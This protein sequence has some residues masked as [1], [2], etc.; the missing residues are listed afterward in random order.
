MAQTSTFID[1]I[2]KYKIN[3][4]RIQ[5]D[6]AQGRLSDKATVIRKSLVDTIVAV[7]DQEDK[8]KNL[9]FIYGSTNHCNFIPLDGQQRLTTLF[10]FH[11]Y[12]DWVADREAL[13]ENIDYQF[14]YATRDSST[15]FCEDFVKNKDVLAVEIKEPYTNY[16][17]R[18]EAEKEKN[19][20]EREK[21]LKSIPYPKNPSDIIRN[22]PWFFS[23]WDADPTVAGMLVMLDEIHSRYI[24]DFSGDFKRINHARKR[25][26]DGAVQFQFQ[27]LDNFTR[28]DDLFIK[29]NSRG[30]GLTDFEIFKSKIVEDF[31]NSCPDK[32]SD[33]KNKIDGEWC[34]FL[35]TL[36]SKV[37]KDL[38]KHNVDI[39]YQRLLKFLIASEA[40]ALGQKIA[41][42]ADELFERNNKTM[43]FAHNAY[44]GCDV[45]F[46]P[47][48]LTRV[49]EDVDF[50][51]NKKTS[52]LSTEGLMSKELSDLLLAG[53]QLSYDEFI[54]AYAWLRFSLLEKDD[55][56]LKDWMRTIRHLLDD[57]NVDSSTGLINAL[58]GVNTLLELYTQSRRNIY[59]W[60]ANTKVTKIEGLSNYQLQEEVV[61]AQLRVRPFGLWSSVIEETEDNKFMN[62][63]IGFLLET[64]DIARIEQD[65]DI[66]ALNE[67]SLDEDEHKF[68]ERFQ[69]Y[70]E[71]ATA[72]FANLQIDNV[73]IKN[74]L[75]VRALLKF[76]DYFIKARNK[77]NIANHPNDRDYSWHAILNIGKGYAES[78]II[79]KKL[80][81]DVQFSIEDI[82]RSLTMIA[83]R[84]IP[85]AERWR[86]ILSGKYA[87]QI[88]ERSHKGFLDFQANEESKTLNVRVLHT[89]QLNGFHDELS[90]LTLYFML[91]EKSE[92]AEKVSYE[93]VKSNQEGAGLILQKNTDGK[94][95]TIKITHWDNEWQFYYSDGWCGN[96]INN[97]NCSIECLLRYCKYLLKGI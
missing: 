50:I 40:A 81:D 86:Q 71:K 29:M 77:R 1:L 20:A 17:A 48:L 16:H 55:E 82:T 24:N 61:K 80:L 22:Q 76:G 35:W 87:H 9:N 23:Q 84:E 88:L 91:K 39:I 79:F 4:P 60:L 52:P 32:E 14:S 67:N 73:L 96:R 66:F 5:R 94:E 46:S 65:K 26:I 37:T 53:K 95:E 83:S 36:K 15:R 97:R 63:Q 2:K 93:S 30:L 6:Y 57:S 89:S 33:F 44:K 74:H 75:L 8:I 47:A 34:D 56:E 92:I 11:L 68:F 27:A 45:E 18:K 49:F 28:T 85:N 69:T 64:A 42:H 19:K 43:R 54:Q 78:R 90:S 7:L 21:L 25:L 70:K 13:S 38:A 62:G 31:E 59:D 58:K 41:T 10:L 72:I 51:C 12:L 3:I